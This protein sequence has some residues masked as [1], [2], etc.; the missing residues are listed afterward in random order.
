MIS[1]VVKKMRVEMMYQVIMFYPDQIIYNHA[2]CCELF[3][4]LFLHIP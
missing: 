2:L 1:G 4:P 3:P